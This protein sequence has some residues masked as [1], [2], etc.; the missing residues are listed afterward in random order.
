M[1]Y[2]FLGIIKVEK[3]LQKYKSSKTRKNHNISLK[4]YTLKGVL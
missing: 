2:F 4:N 1:V 3:I